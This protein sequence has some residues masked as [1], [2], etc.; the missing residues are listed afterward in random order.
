[1]KTLTDY[2]CKLHMFLR[3]AVLNESVF[4]FLGLKS[5]SLPVIISPS[6]TMYLT[7]V[8]I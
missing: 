5:G 6:F 3:E 4:N 2:A 1:M 7:D 8:I